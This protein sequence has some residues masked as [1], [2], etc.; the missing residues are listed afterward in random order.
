MDGTI[1]RNDNINGPPVTTT[2][3]IMFSTSNLVLSRQYTLFTHTIACLV[4]CGNS[5]GGDDDD[6]DDD[7][8][9][10]DVTS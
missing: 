5:A 9:N 10:D 8:D 1:G 4:I 6:D 3:L 2:S 7:D